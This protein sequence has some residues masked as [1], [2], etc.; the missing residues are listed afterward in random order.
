M[1]I[2]EYQ[3]ALDSK[4]R[5]IV[6]SK[7]REGLGDKFVLT[8]GL[9]GCIYAYPMDEWAKL[10]EKLKGLPLTNKN[11]RT[12]VRFFFSG[13][14]EVTPDKQGRVLIPQSLCEYGNIKKEIVSIGVATRIEIWSK[15]NWDEYN[16]SNVDFD[17]IAEQ[18]SELGI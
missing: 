9:D 15:E 5:M 6:P 17:S 11:A 14:N 13:A 3:H 12:F 8:K 10:E 4:N 2:G 7:L 18:M 16:N 1:F